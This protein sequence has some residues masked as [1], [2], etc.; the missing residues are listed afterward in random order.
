MLPCCDGEIMLYIYI[1]IIA[2]GDL[3]VGIDVEQ[4]VDYQC[5]KFRP[6][7]TTRLQLLPNFVDVVESVTERRDRQTH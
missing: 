6:L 7:L 1:Y 2:T 4:D 3:L 5:A